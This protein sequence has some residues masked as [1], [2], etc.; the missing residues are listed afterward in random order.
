MNVVK[1]NLFG[2]TLTDRADGKK[3][4]AAILGQTSPPIALDFAGVVSLGSSFGDEIIPP[5]AEGQENTISILNAN[6]V[7]RNC[8]RRIIEETTITVSFE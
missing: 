4:L 8:I 7:I 2:S 6:S 1:L 3:A 5:L